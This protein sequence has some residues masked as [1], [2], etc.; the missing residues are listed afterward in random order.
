MNTIKSL[1]VLF[2]LFFVFISSANA[3][4][5]L[6]N[7]PPRGNN[8]TARTAPCAGYNEVNSSAI[9]D[10]PIKSEDSFFVSSLKV[11]FKDISKL[12]NG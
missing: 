2:V 5:E 11:L 7:P 12:V 10:F 6:S 9:T 1:S 3:H 8:G 4:I